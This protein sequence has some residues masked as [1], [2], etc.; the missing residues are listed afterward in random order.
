MDAYVVVL[1]LGRR[2]DESKKRGAAEAATSTAMGQ[3]PQA[4]T[5]PRAA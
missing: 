5:R 4:V 1:R 2:C 3:A